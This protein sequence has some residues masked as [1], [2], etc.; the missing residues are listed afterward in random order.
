MGV[1]YSFEK[2]AL[3]AQK[4]MALLMDRK[5]KQV[6]QNFTIWFEYL[7]DTNPQIKEAVNRL[8][9]E[10]G[11]FN[12]EVA[13]EIYNE[14][15]SSEKETKQIRETNR[16]VQQ[17]METLLREIRASSTGLS[18]YEETLEDFA[19]KADGASVLDL[20]EMVR[21]VIAETRQMSEQSHSLNENL[22]KASE[23]IE[24]LK[25]K[26][27]VVE[28]ENLTDPLTGIANRKKFDVVLDELSARCKSTGEKMCL[29]LSDIDFFKKFND[30]H[31]HL[32]GDQ[33][34]KLVAKTLHTG[35][36]EKG[37]AARYG[38]EEFGIILPET[39]L[40]MAARL[41]D[42]LRQ[43]VSAKKLVKRNT[44]TNVGKITMSFGVAQY[45]PTENIETFVSRADRALY[46]AKEAGRNQV[47]IDVP[48]M[49][50]AV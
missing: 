13:K 36:D 19:G 2:A 32:F 30:E 39:N 4:T 38:G 10:K 50:E 46:K 22:Q 3:N 45:D 14:F 29:V 41:A 15:F 6:P 49:A 34:L 35:V 7:S 9:A 20:Q 5:I 28:N 27:E 17:S 24:I 42:T 37:I 12:D 8:L 43:S 44:G 40:Q 47:K 26:L 16:L 18:N 25:R 1:E 31:G 33:V 11:K 23:E 21:G 48:V